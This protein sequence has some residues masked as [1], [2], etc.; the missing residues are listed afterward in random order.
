MCRG[1][2]RSGPRAPPSPNTGFARRRA[3][4]SVSPRVLASLGSRPRVFASSPS[5]MR[6]NCWSRMI[7]PP[8]LLR[9]A[10]ASRRSLHGHFR[11]L[12]V[13]R[14]DVA[15]PAN[16]PASVVLGALAIAALALPSPVLCYYLLAVLCPQSGL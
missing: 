11:V 2:R 4:T 5:E 14:L 1:A 12:A 7:V 13:A 3:D 8:Y 15:N 10:F 16:S 9:L 6:D